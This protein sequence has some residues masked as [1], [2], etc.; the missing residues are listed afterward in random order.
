MKRGAVSYVC[1]VSTEGAM[2]EMILRRA[3]SALTTLTGAGVVD[4]G[5]RRAVHRTRGLPMGTI[6]EWFAHAI[7]NPDGLAGGIG[8]AMSGRFVTAGPRRSARERLAV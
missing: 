7:T 8:G 6:Q 5:R 2:L 3:L 4:A 1:L